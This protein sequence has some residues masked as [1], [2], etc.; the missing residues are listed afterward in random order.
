MAQ[1]NLC[2]SLT[3]LTYALLALLPRGRAWGNVNGAPPA[4]SPLYQYWQA[5]AAAFLDA[6]TLICSAIAE[7]FPS[8]AVQTLDLW[9]AD[10]G[11]PTPC[12]PYPN[13]VAKVAALGGSS[14]AYLQQVAATA[15]WA[16]TIGVDAT[17]G[18][19]LFQVGSDQVGPGI[20]LATL[21]VR[22]FLSQSV[23]YAGSAVQS[24][25]IAGS[26]WGTGLSLGCGPDITPLECLF[27]R[28][29]PAHLVVVYEVHS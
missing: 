22:V 5:V 24:A 25:L 19:G 3:D 13:L 11:L 1:G 12:D 18:A 4:S 28:L 23:A 10:Y 6:E 7:F 17:E 26:N 8:T 15:G 16:V 29:I 9:D 27:V 21:W 20:P 2:P 14:A